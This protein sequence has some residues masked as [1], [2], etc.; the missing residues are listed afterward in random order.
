MLTSTFLPE[1]PDPQLNYI[2]CQLF[3]AARQ[4]FYVVDL[5][6]A[7]TYTRKRQLCSQAEADAKCAPV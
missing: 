5:E 2:G 4:A 1:N 3:H 7:R 6:L